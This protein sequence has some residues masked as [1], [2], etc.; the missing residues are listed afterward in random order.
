MKR[1]G[2]VVGLIALVALALG[3]CGDFQQRAAEAQRMLED[4]R[5][6]AETAQQAAAQNAGRILEL[7]DWIEALEATLGELQQSLGG[8]SADEGE[9][10]P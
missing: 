5:E 1:Y 4:T 10:S 9:A 6:A 2:L 8:L 3:G 7:E